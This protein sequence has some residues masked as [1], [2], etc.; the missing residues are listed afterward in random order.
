MDGFGACAEM[1]DDRLKMA[2]G[3]WKMADGPVK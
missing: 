3:R 2:D 1:A